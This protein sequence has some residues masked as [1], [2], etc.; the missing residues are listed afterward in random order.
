MQL[1]VCLQRFPVH[2]L[3]LV[4]AWT[5]FLYFLL[6][7]QCFSNISVTYFSYTSFLVNFW[8][9]SSICMIGAADRRSWSACRVFPHLCYETPLQLPD[10]LT[11]FGQK[12]I[13]KTVTKGFIQ[14]KHRGLPVYFQSHQSYL[15]TTSVRL[16]EQKYGTCESQVP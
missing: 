4:H 9:F 16:L 2:V 12:E 15:A 5:S 7:F 14:R 1:M 10:I 11:C 8:S 3:G 6:Y 13:V